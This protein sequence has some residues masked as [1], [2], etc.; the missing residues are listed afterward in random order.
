MGASGPFPGLVVSPVGALSCRAGSRRGWFPGQGTLLTSSLLHLLS[1][2]NPDTARC[3]LLLVGTGSSGLR[4]TLDLLE[5]TK[6]LL[7][8]SSY[9]ASS[10][11]T[12]ED[13]KLLVTQYLNATDSHWCSWSVSPGSGGSR[14]PV[15]AGGRGGLW[16]SPVSRSPQLSQAGLLTSFV[17]AQLL[18]LY[19][20]LLFT[21]PGTPVFSYGDEI[22]LQATLPG[23]VP[24]A[25]CPVH[26]V[27]W[28]VPEGQSLG[29]AGVGSW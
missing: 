7:L 22:G 10:A 5:S 24:C 29:R 18:R 9:L 19:Q 4:P 14:E 17:P 27:L 8:T 25:L 6:D 13:T 26:W 11:F 23:Q 28:V 16:G 1:C 3:R 2:T 12:A 15:G 20:L 21:L